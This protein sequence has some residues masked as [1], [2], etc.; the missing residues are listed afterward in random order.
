MYFMQLDNGNWID[1][2]TLGT[3]KNSSAKEDSS[4]NSCNSQNSQ[5]NMIC[6][7]NPGGSTDF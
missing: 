6:S 3:T 2:G 1:I 7:Q 5:G 4:A